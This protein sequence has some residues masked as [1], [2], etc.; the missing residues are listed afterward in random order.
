MHR[1]TTRL[2]AALAA[3]TIALAPLACSDDDDT[4][5]VDDRIVADDRDADDGVDRDGDGVADRTGDVTD[6]G[7]V[8]DGTDADD[9]AVDR[10]GDGIA[11]SADDRVDDRVD[12]DGVAD[13]PDADDTVADEDG[14]DAGAAA[15]A[16]ALRTRVSEAGS[17]DA[18]RTR[19]IEVL[20]T[21][22]AGLPGDPDIGGIE[23]GDGDGLDDDGRVLVADDGIQACVTVEG[24]DVSVGQGAC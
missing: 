19:S 16:E 6:D 5:D 11:D 10:D 2:L 17:G 8:V 4:A 21:A 1:R 12:D 7:V 23:D 3:G 9:V 20:R 22:A 18:D 13:R 15:A 14:V 24:A